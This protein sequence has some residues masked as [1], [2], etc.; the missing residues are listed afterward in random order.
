MAE[1]NP[2]AAVEV[3]EVVVVAR[4]NHREGAWRRL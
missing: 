4:R 1:L 3:G 2:T